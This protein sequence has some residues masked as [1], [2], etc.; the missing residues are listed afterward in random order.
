[1][2]S[3]S[4]YPSSLSHPKPLDSTIASRALT[5]IY[6]KL[7]TF[8]SSDCN[9]ESAIPTNN[10]DSDSHS[11]QL[12]HAEDK[13]NRAF[14]RIL[15][16]GPVFPCKVMEDEKYERLEIT[17]TRKQGLKLWVSDKS[18]HTKVVEEVDDDPPSAEQYR[19]TYYSNIDL[20][21]R[22]YKMGKIVM[23][24]KNV[25]FNMK[26]QMMM[27]NTYD[28]RRWFMSRTD[29]VSDA[30]NVESN[31]FSTNEAG[32]AI[33]GILHRMVRA[34]YMK[35]GTFPNIDTFIISL[36]SLIKKGEVVNYY[37]FMAICRAQH[38]FFV[39]KHDIGLEKYGLYKKDHTDWH[40]AGVSKSRY[41]LIQDFMFWLSFIPRQYDEMI[42]NYMFKQQIYV[43]E[44]CPIVFL[45]DGTCPCFW[46]PPPVGWY[47]LSVS[48]FFKV[49]L[50]GTKE[51]SCG[52]VFRDCKG[53][54]LEIFHK[55]LPDA[56]SRD[57]VFLLGVHH[58]IDEILRSK[59]EV[60]EIIFEIDHKTIVKV[61]NEEKRIPV[62]YL[63]LYK[64]IIDMLSKFDVCRIEFPHSQGNAVANRVAYIASHLTVG[65]SFPKGDRGFET[66]VMCDQLK[67]PRHEIFPKKGI[68]A[69]ESSDDEFSSEESEVGF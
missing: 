34:V 48:G 68:E 18:I 32:D 1:M 55:P 22:R 56:T 30:T 54:I 5:T 39:K 64:K 3:R 44:S 66:Q 24:L 25:V 52:E 31:A 42:Y 14:N 46:H 40:A 45:T 41:V 59:S 47:K 15:K 23:E 21:Q 26:P 6:W 38:Q 4:L 36:V 58:G 43:L 50:D 65:Q 35:E 33:N 8:A 19:R 29:A 69:E 12:P 27:R 37:Q 16:E 60:K 53:R 2:A 61:L 17:G 9:T 13:K 63:E 49:N 20:P 7:R 10:S 57:E 28:S 62:E 51:A 67:I 11:K